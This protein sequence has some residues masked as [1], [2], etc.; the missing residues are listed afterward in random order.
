MFGRSNNCAATRAI[1]SPDRVTRM[2]HTT[3]SRQSVEVL[4]ALGLGFYTSSHWLTLPSF[5][6]TAAVTA[7]LVASAV[8]AKYKF[9]RTSHDPLLGRRKY[10]SKM[11]ID[12]PAPNVTYLDGPAVGKTNKLLHELI[13]ANK[14]L[15]PGLSHTSHKWQV[16]FAKDLSVW[17][18]CV[19]D[20][21]LVCSKDI[22]TML[23]R[24]E[25][26]VLLSTQIAHVLAK[27]KTECISFRALLRH[28]AAITAWY[29]AF[30]FPVLHSYPVD[31]GVLLATYHL[32]SYG[33]FQL[34]FR[35]LFLEADE[36]GLA[37]ASNMGATEQDA[38]SL[39]EKMIRVR[40]QL[41][42]ISRIRAMCYYEYRISALKQKDAAH[43]AYMLSERDKN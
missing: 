42:L 23:S 14:R 41:P 39:M 43:R 2:I 7:P 12:R 18:D 20:G 19:E 8:L 27:H 38:I 34:K 1:R 3:G 21:T 40:R 16:M 37:L 31:A 33:I 36:L 9:S 5:A 15:F 35:K 17:V 6:K 32:L 4:A 22:V 24:N 10:L 13:R 29:Y 25:L 28:V 11:W 30:F 26:L